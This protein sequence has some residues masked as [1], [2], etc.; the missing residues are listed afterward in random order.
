MSTN[1]EFFVN[2]QAP[3][4]DAPMITVRRKGVLILTKKAAQMLG[5]DVKFVQIGY[6]AKSRSVAL[7][8]A[9][10]D[11]SGRYTMRDM[12]NDTFLV[13]AKPMFAHYGLD[14]ERAQSFDVKKFDKGLVGVTLPEN[15]VSPA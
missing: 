9:E 2:S 15:V 12:K 8:K 4:N 11:T 1:F 7:R 13:N 5:D 10:S 3:K 14:V 6:D